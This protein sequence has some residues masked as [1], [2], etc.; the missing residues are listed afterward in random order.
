MDLKFVVQ[1]FFFGPRRTPS[2]E[3]S[4]AKF[5]QKRVFR[6]KI[7][8]F[9]VCY[10]Y[11]PQWGAHRGVSVTMGLEKWT[12]ISTGTQFGANEA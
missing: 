6:P 2:A 3:L 11:A 7:R 8:V 9:E 12:E 1:K 10:T 5:L 4:Y